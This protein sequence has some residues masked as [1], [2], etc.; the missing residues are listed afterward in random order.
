M[1]PQIILSF[2]C[3]KRIHVFHIL[4]R[5]DKREKWGPP[6]WGE[7]IRAALFGFVWAKM[8]LCAAHAEK[9]SKL[10]ENL[11]SPRRVFIQPPAHWQV[12]RKDSKM[13]TLADSPTERLENSYRVAIVSWFIIVWC[14]SFGRSEPHLKVITLTTFLWLDQV[15]TL[16]PGKLR[17]TEA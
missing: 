14:E 12:W 9:K 1:T 5:L 17:W 15:Q 11:L 4:V 3:P 16:T 2:S 10:L 7:E 13:D 6:N 8:Q